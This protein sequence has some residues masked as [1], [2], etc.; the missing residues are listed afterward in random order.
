[1]DFSPFTIT[2]KEASLL[3]TENRISEDNRHCYIL[4]VKLRLVY[5]AGPLPQS[6]FKKLPRLVNGIPLGAGRLPIDRSHA[7]ITWKYVEGC[8][9]TITFI[10]LPISSDE[11]EQTRNKFKERLIKQAKPIFGDITVK[12]SIMLA[13]CVHFDSE[14]FV[15]D[16]ADPKVEGGGLI[17]H[18]S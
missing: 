13:H 1:M 14:F 2:P 8:G 3:L 11:A 9:E 15:N 7:G 17:F 16:I 4:Q 12:A 5:G 6:C 10:S 18:E